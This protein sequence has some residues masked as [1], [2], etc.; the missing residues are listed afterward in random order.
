LLSDGYAKVP[1]DVL[2][3]G[4]TVGALTINYQVS[5]EDGSVYYRIA[6]IQTGM[7]EVDTLKIYKIIESY[8]ADIIIL[9]G[10]NIKTTN[11][12]PLT[13]TF[14]VKHRLNKQIFECYLTRA[15]NDNYNIETEFESPLKNDSLIEREKYFWL[16]RENRFGPDTLIFDDGLTVI[17]NFW[18]WSKEGEEKIFRANGTLALIRNY[19]GGTQQNTKCYY[20]DGS[21]EYD[22]LSYNMTGTSTWWYPTGVK[23]ETIEYKDGR[24]NGRHVT[25][26]FNGKIKT[27]GHYIGGF[28]DRGI[29]DGN[30]I[31]YDSLGQIKAKEIYKRDSL[32]KK[33]TY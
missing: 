15:E 5:E 23:M 18:N 31:Y 3:V 14:Y 17:Q 11:A 24:R 20:E 25:Y 9:P 1:V 2:M 30:W 8:D 26:Y 4:K 27:T 10:T 12:P 33:I 6:T 22:V 16:N 7:R 28:Y 29:K 32:I 13:S 19:K 21:I